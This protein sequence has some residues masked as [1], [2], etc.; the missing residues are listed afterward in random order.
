MIPAPRARRLAA[1]LDLDVDDIPICLA[2]LSFVSSA[3][4]DDDEPKIRGALVAFTPLLWDEGLAEPAYAAVE[5]AAQ[6]GIPD[7]AAALADLD[8]RGP[9]TPIA[10]AIVRRLA[11]DLSYRSKAA[12]AAMW[13]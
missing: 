6:R 5:R 13:N 10:R 4:H 11:S 12:W 2:C 3:L 8:A 9:R 1:A 7:A